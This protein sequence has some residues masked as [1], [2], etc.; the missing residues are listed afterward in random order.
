MVKHAWLPALALA[1]LCVLAR[2][3]S[4]AET[5]A[6][7]PKTKPATVSAAAKSKAP[8]TAPQAPAKPAAK[9]S[10]GDGIIA[11]NTLRIYLSRSATVTVHNARGQL[12]FHVDSSRPTEYLPLSGVHAGFL[13]LTL[14][15]GSLETTRKLLYSGK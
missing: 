6:R 13:Y 11:Q 1:S 15:S 8:A 5:G 7:T 9:P 12:L 2:A 10:L 3:A 4:S 14:R